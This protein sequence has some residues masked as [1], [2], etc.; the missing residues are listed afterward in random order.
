[1]E[2]CPA[3]SVLDSKGEKG[4]SLGTE[5]NGGYQIRDE[6]MDGWGQK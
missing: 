2:V 5:S 4:G 3:V 6:M 1:M